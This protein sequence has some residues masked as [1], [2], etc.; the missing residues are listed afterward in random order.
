MRTPPESP[1]E[2]N[3]RAILFPKRGFSATEILLLANAAVAAVLFA[4]WGKD[5]STELRQWASDGW[6]A[7]HASHAYA[8][9]L[10]TLF[11][12][13]SP[14]HLASNMAALLAAS[15]AVEFLAGGGWTIAAYLVTGL[16]AAWVSYA[17]HGAPPLSVGASGAVFGLL[18]CTIAFLIRRRGMF[19]YA[20]RWKVWRVY[21]PLFILLFVPAIANADVHAHAGGFACGL[22]LG[23][24]LPPH[25]RIARLA[26][27]PPSG[28]PRGEGAMDATSM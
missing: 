18:G 6:H 14:G 11:V 7:V 10:A 27:E 15:A 17:G 12:H 23:I 28:M 13:A 21:I 16:G 25:P 5:Y 2:V 9:F 26:A 22:V 20:K 8:W 1:E 24:W 4:V 3:L 19:N